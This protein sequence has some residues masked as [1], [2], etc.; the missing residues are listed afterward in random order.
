V[1]WGRESGAADRAYIPTHFYVAWSVIFWSSV[2][3]VY[4]LRCECVF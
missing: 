4:L 1:K 2:W 3:L